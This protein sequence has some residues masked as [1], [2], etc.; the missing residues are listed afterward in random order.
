MEVT[1]LDTGEWIECAEGIAQVLSVVDVF[2]EEFSSEYRAGRKELGDYSHT[3]VS[4]KVLCSHDGALRSRQLTSYSNRA[5]VAD[6][7]VE[8]L[9][10]VSK[11]QSE[12]S[13]RF[14]KFL[15]YS[16]SVPIEHT[17]T[18]WLNVPEESVHDL[19]EHL[20]NFAANGS[21]VFTYDELFDYLQ[22]KAPDLNVDGVHREYSRTTNNLRLAL[23]NEDLRRLDKRAALVGVTA[24]VR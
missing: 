18:A 8:A 16:A 21:G 14:E 22:E 9:G 10:I 7:S 19:A 23:R 2:T 13:E 15:K 4:Y 1:A 24:S 5:G 3:L 17:Y 6:A 11:L 20:N 12:Q